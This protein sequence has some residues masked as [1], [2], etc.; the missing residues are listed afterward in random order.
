M[1]LAGPHPD[2]A[3]DARRPQLLEP[4][5]ETQ[6]PRLSEAVAR[7][8]R[9]RGRS[10]GRP[11]R[12]R[13][14]AAAR[15]ARR[16]RHDRRPGAEEDP[17]R[18]LRDCRGLRRRPAPLARARAVRAR[19]TRWRT[20]PRSSS[21]ATARASRPARS[22]S[23]R[24]RGVGPRCGRAARRSA[25]ATARWR[26][27]HR[28]DAVTDFF[29]FLL[30]DAGPPDKPQTIN[31]MLARSESLLQQRPSAATP[32]SR[33]RSSSTQAAYHVTVGDRGAGRA[34]AAPRSWPW[35]AGRRRRRPCVP[36]R[37]ACTASPSRCS[38]RCRRPARARSRRRCTTVRC[39]HSSAR[40][41]A[42]SRW[43]SSPRTG[44]TARRR[45]G[46][47]EA[48]LAILKTAERSYPKLEASLLGDLALC[49]AAAGRNDGAD[50]STPR[51]LPS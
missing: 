29:E 6:A 1:L 8:A 25:S 33:P 36:R 31:S 44:A 41:P 19:P 15:A 2:R 48:G 24:S 9:P 7:R 21:A 42:T 27:S 16:P 35:L 17:R 10:P 3:Q 43:R 22:P 40:P 20:A 34:Q 32:S 47:A 26:C 12:R 38:R 23:P 4:I 18:A 14:E 28:S 51:R 11:P 45:R 46:G 39:R 13:R 30:T 37:A 5:V 49:R 50:A